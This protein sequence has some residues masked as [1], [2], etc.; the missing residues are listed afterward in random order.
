M[1]YYSHNDGFYDHFY[2]LPI[3]LTTETK[4]VVHDALHVNVTL[5]LINIIDIPPSSFR[6]ENF[7]EVDEKK[8]DEALNN[9]IG[10]LGINLKKFT[11][12]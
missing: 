10:I 3:K 9:T 5:P 4:D 2:R 8:F 7:L 11:F 12:I 1:F 6:Y